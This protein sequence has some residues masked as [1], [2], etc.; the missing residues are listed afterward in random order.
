LHFDECKRKAQRY[1]ILQGQ[2]T[3]FNIQISAAE[4]DRKITLSENGKQKIIVKDTNHFNDFVE[5]LRRRFGM[6]DTMNCEELL[7]EMSH[8]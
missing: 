8:L 7:I 5:K 4:Q 3:K 2:S 1:S 6:A